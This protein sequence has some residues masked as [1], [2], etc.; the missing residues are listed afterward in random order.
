MGQTVR[1]SVTQDIL[2][3]SGNGLAIYIKSADNLAWI[4]DQYGV[5]ELLSNYLNIS[6]TNYSVN[7][8]DFIT[9]ETAK[10]KVIA[11]DSSQDT[12]AVTNGVNSAISYCT[13]NNIKE[14]YFGDGLYIIDSVTFNG[15]NNFRLI[16]QGATIRYNS[17]DSIFKFTNCEDV[18]ITGFHFTSTVSSYSDVGFIRAETNNSFFNIFNNK[19]ENFPRA[20][21]IVSNLAGGVYSEGFI[22]FMNQFVDTPNYSNVNQC[23][24]ELGSDGEYSQIISN[25]FYSVPSAVRFVD[26]ANGIFA[27]NNCLL[28]TGTA[29][30]GTY[31][32]AVIYCEANSNSGKIDIVNNKINHNSNGDIAIVFKGDASKPNNAFRIID[33]DIL[34]H[35]STTQSLCIYGNNAPYSI[36][37]NNKLRGRT[38]TPN[39]TAMILE[40]CDNVQLDNLFIQ[41]FENGIQLITSENLQ[42]GTILYEN[43]TTENFIVDTTSSNFVYTNKLPSLESIDSAK[44]ISN[45]DFNKTIYNYTSNSLAVTIPTTGLKD[46]LTFNL[47]AVSGDITISE[48]SNTFLPSGDKT[49]NAGDYAIVYKD[50]N[51]SNFRF[52]I[53][54]NVGGTVSPFDGVAE[55]QAVVNRATTEGFTQPSAGTKTALETFVADLQSIGAWQLSDL[56]LMFSY[57]DTNVFN[58]ATIN[59]KSPSDTLAVLVNSPTYSV[60]GFKGNGSNSYID[61]SFNPSTYG[62]N[63]TQDNATRILVVHTATTNTGTAL[64]RMD[65]NGTGLNNLSANTNGTLQ[66]INTASNLGVSV[67]LSGTGLKALTRQDSSNVKLYNQAVETSTTSTSASP[68][69]ENLLIFRDRTNYGDCGIGLYIVGGDMSAIISGIRSA[70]GTYLTTIGLSNFS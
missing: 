68:N 7:V 44:T 8:L 65:G 41:Y 28:S 39:D 25:Q 29:Y 63:F 36:I 61:T 2:A 9:D 62:G 40:D 53:F 27:F 56:I 18:Y 42:V 10:A 13:A 37:E 1:R 60:N 24:V 19:F 11:R 33:N 45:A 48:G 16:G 20:G 51:T 5:E 47:D 3:K 52:L 43:I 70:Y 58:F 38:G 67:D 17:G 32:N 49:I 35:G 22:I 55:V 64:N 12:T 30:T 21:M 59:L 57:N 50:G 46:D 66:R 23:A 26:G 4:K 34:V 6:S 31:D 15:F 14:L 54:P 69:N